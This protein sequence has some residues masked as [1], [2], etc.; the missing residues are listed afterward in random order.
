MRGRHQERIFL[1][2]IL[3]SLVTLAESLLLPE[4]HFS[5]QSITNS[6]WIKHLNVR[7][8]TIKLLEENMGRIL[9]DINKQQQYLF[10]S[11][12][13]SY[14]NKNKNKGDPIKR[15][16]FYTTKGITNNVTH[17]GLVTQQFITTH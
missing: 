13:Q 12:S 6:K 17:K 11:I 7:P 1:I 2:H 16:S 4:S 15:E 5:Q 14:G 10:Q 3:L 9:F 8:D